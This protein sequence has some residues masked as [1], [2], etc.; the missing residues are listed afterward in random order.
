[1]TIWIL[2]PRDSL[3]FRD[4]RPFSAVSSS[5]GSHARSLP[6]VPPSTVA[7]A[8][9]TRSGS[10]DEGLFIGSPSELL[11]KEI[12]GPLLVNWQT[13]T[14][15]FLAPAPADAL[16]L[17]NKDTKLHQ[18]YRLHPLKKL[19]E[20]D[21]ASEYLLVGLLK[22]DENKDKGKPRG[23]PRY[24]HWEM[25]EEWLKDKPF[26]LGE[27]NAQSETKL[28]HDIQ[29]KDLGIANLTQDIRTH[30][31][32]QPESQTGDDGMLFGTYGLEFIHNPKEGL[33][34]ASNLGIFVQTTADNLSE[35]AGYLGGEGRI[36]HWRKT[37]LNFPNCPDEVK[38]SIENKS[39][40]KSFCR[41]ILLT[42]AYFKKGYLPTWLCNLE[43][44]TATVK[45]VACERP[46][47]LSGWDYKGRQPKATK[48]Y[49]PAGAV[50]FLELEG[51]PESREKWLEAIWM[52]NVSDDEQSRR[53]GFGL[54][55][56]GV[57]D[58]EEK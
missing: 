50:Y 58:G 35:G 18:L 56:L 38:T 34:S 54:A 20:S 49:V 19:G 27:K 25:F 53:D 26:G 30:V 29:P 24:W 13:D 1:M 47:T 46:V 28:Y 57:W 8:V 21:L 43:G 48:R 40:E 4:G 45:A 11:K 6:F 3:I 39:V 23:M 52:K 17:E 42:P 10:N 12:L 51:T 55:A 9:R 22:D 32:I 36:V 37:N 33:S 2:E 14:F 31:K 16:M 5:I 41:L 44:V 15:T 7:G